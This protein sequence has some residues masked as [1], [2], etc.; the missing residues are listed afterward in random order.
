M[1]PEFSRQIIKEYS[2]FK[3]HE[4]PFSGSRVVQCGRTDRPTDRQTDMTKL[5]VAS[6]NFARAPNSD[7]F[8]IQVNWM[9]FI[10]NTECVYCAVR[11]GSLY[12]IHLV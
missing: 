10:T 3:F 12:I 1:K 9:L 4:N 8:P 11:T 5:I 7:Y 2:N 6:R